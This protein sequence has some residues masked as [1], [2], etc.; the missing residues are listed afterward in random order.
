SLEEICAIKQGFV[1]AALFL[2]KAGFDGIELY[3]AHGY[4]LAQFL[5]KTTN[6]RTDQYAGSIVNRAR[7]ITEIADEIR[8]QNRPDFILGIKI[9]SVEFQAK[10]FTAEDAAELCELLEKHRFDFVELSGGT[11]V[12]GGLRS[13]RGMIDALKTVNGIGL[14][15]P[16]CSEPSLTRDIMGGRTDR[17]VKPII[18]D[19]DFGITATLAGLQMQLIGNRYAPLGPSSEKDMAVGALDSK[20]RLID[21]IDPDFLRGKGQ[22]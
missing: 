4:L 13:A 15:R 9:N 18:D 3:G 7:F 19:N 12:T 5:S 20:A 2:E 21:H 6:L 14:G 10:G 8:K 17:A 1:H 16:A 11:Y 22:V